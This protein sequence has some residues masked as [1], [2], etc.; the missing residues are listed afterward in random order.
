M[1]TSDEIQWFAIQARVGGEAAAE[2][3]LRTL[4]IE[5]LLPL[6]RRRVHHATRVP[7]MVL[8]PLFPGYFF[9]R[10]CAAVLLRAVK[11]SRGVIRVVGGGA[12]PWPLD[13]SIIAD[14]R[15]RIGAEGWVELR[16]RPLQAGDRISI[17]AG[18]LAGWSGI[19]DSELTDAERVVILIETL[20]QGRVVIRRDYLE[21]SEAA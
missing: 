13:D 11:Y 19:F 21:L 17:T 2:A 20:Q 18:P 1:S 14:L 8:R 16:E 9:A 5:T 15:E 3:N 10:F 6:V 4:P 7:R 12:Q